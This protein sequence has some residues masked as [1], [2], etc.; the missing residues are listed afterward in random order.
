MHLNNYT[1]HIVKKKIIKKIARNYEI[2]V[3]VETGTFLGDMIYMLKNNFDHIYSIEI[4]KKLYDFNV[5]R[6]KNVKKIS[7]FHG[8]SGIILNN[9]LQIINQPAIFWLDGHYSGSFT[10]FGNELTPII[11]E[12]NYISKSP[13]INKHIIIIDDARCFDEKNGY[14]DIVVIKKWAADNKF[15]NFTIQNDMIFITNER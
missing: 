12:L 8:D 6:F 7:L 5:R 11:N 15:T 14:P 10:G 4:Q 13:L 2:K 3:L 9:I 1:P